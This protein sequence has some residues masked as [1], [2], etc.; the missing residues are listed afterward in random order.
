MTTMALKCLTSLC[1]N[2]I[3]REKLLEF[4]FE[5]KANVD[6][7]RYTFMEILEELM[8]RKSL[9]IDV[10]SFLK[11]MNDI[12]GDRELLSKQMREVIYMNVFSASKKLVTKTVELMLA[13][14]ENVWL[15]VINLLNSQGTDDVDLLLLIEMLKSIEGINC[16]PQHIMKILLD[17]IDTPA[18]S[19][20]AATIFVAMLR[21]IEVEKH[22]V[23]IDAADEMFEKSLAD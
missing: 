20:R 18:T 16:K 6:D 4:V 15:Q 12:R 13:C 10:V 11:S 23:I 3:I 1:S 2:E 19:Q 14:E 8:S 22:D 17:N 5:E 7:D 21:D 9:K